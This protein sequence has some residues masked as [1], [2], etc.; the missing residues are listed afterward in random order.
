MV[1]GQTWYFQSILNRLY[2]NGEVIDKQT[3]AQIVEDI[4]NEL[5][6]AFIN[7]CKSLSDNQEALVVVIAKEKE[8]SSA[9]SQ[10]FIRKYK[11][12]GGQQCEPCHKGAA[13]A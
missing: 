5:E 8:V 7:Y 9:L 12:A 2:E 3:I 11:S 4:I 6:D 10:E 1:D 13:K